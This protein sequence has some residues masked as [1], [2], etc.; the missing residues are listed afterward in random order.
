M[1][2]GYG[3]S[4]LLVEM[5]SELNFPACWYSFSPEDNDPQMF[6]RYCVQ[7]IR[8][9]SPNFGMSYRTL[10]RTGSNSDWRTQCGFLVSAL[11]S[12]IEGQF[13]L[14]FDDLHWIDG[15]RELEEALSLIIREG[16]A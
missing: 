7:S 14:L 8:T 11:E 6:V 10:T 15:K 2:A 3:K 4:A 12:D 13:A 16:S 5:I 1:P 9:I